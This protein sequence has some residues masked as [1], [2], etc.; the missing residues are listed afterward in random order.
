MN[1]GYNKRV[2]ERVTGN[3]EITNLHHDSYL[4]DMDIP[5]QGPYTDALVGGHQSR[6]ISLNTGSDDWKSRPE[7]WKLLLGRCWGNPTSG[8]IGMVG[9]DYPWPEANDGRLA[10]ADRTQRPYPMTA[11]QKAVYYRGLTAKRPV[12]IRNVALV[13]G[14]D[15]LKNIGNYQ[16]N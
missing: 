8:A 9:A 13:T 4:I 10:P 7:A 15:V 16:K 2:I 14:S 3:I 12:N 6:H 1:S 11:S 5:M